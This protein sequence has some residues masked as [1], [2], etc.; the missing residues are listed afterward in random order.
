MEHHL[1]VPVLGPGIHINQTQAPLARNVGSLRHEH[2]KVGI[3][4]QATSCANNGRRPMA[5]TCKQYGVLE[6]L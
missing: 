2:E 3:P 4:V 1:C 5:L 6:T